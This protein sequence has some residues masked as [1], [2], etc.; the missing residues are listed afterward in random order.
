V[1]YGNV[2]MNTGSNCVHGLSAASRYPRRGGRFLAHR[3]SVLGINAYR[4]T[5]WPCRTSFHLTLQSVPTLPCEG[6]GQQQHNPRRRPSGLS[7][8]PAHAC[9][10]TAPHRS[11]RPGDISWPTCKSHLM[12]PSSLASSSLFCQAA[13]CIFFV[14]SLFAELLL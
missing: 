11:L 13:R 1:R 10:P 5:S 7:R 8:Q 12:A 4:T 9:V 14:S 3:C 2:E 6:P